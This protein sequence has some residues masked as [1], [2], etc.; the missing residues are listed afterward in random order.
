MFL[1]DHWDHLVSFQNAKVE[2]PQKLAGTFN[3]WNT[4]DKN[5]AMMGE[6]IR[7]RKPKVVL[8]C[9]TFEGRTTEY[10]G[11]IL[12]A[13]VE[14]PILISVDAGHIIA[15]DDGATVIFKEDDADWLPV[16]TA[17]NNR[18]AALH[19][20][21][22]LAFFYCEGVVRDVLD[23]ILS[24]YRV[25]FIYHDSCHVSSIQMQEWPT[26]ERY[27]QPGDIVCYDDA[28]LDIPGNFFSFLENLPGWYCRRNTAADV[29]QMW[30]EKL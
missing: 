13:V 30:C 2:L 26:I 8:E 23:G 15:S 17:R 22:N 1:N 7:L 27:S 5:L 11:N 28:F 18:I 16:V 14:A 21:G 19:A 4:S 24:Q 3:S 9:G 25:E 12:S 20:I 29:K 10:L 6:F